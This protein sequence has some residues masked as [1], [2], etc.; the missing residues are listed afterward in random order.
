MLLPLPSGSSQTNPKTEL[1]HLFGL[2]DAE[3]TP[4]F[5]LIP[6]TPKGGEKLSSFTLSPFRG[7]YFS[8]ELKYLQTQGYKITLKKTWHFN[9]QVHLPTQILHTLFSHKQIIKSDSLKMWINSIY[10]RLSFSKIKPQTFLEFLSD[11]NNPKRALI[12]ESP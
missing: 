4:S 1:K 8:E 9:S 7:I 3:L 5:S 2:A 10:G 12:P 11:R 6:S